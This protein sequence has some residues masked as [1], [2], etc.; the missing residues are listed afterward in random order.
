MLERSFVL[1]ARPGSFVVKGFFPIIRQLP[2]VARTVSQRVLI[3]Y[4]SALLKE[5][6]RKLWKNKFIIKSDTS[7]AGKV[8][9]S[10]SSTLIVCRERL[11]SKNWADACFCAHRLT[12]CFS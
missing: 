4:G 10:V 12:T 1:S 8:K 2:V 11:F 6:L 5:D 3:D 9:C 7:S